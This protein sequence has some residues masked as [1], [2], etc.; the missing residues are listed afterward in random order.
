MSL[1]NKAPRV[2]DLTEYKRLA[3]VHKEPPLREKVPT[4]EERDFIALVA[5]E[6]WGSA[7]QISRLTN[8]ERGV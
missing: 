3:V 7:P 5:R 4:Q 8:S 2:S 6:E 1:F